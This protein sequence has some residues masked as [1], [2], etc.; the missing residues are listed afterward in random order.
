MAL[1]ELTDEYAL[2][3]GCRLPLHYCVDAV[4]SQGRTVQKA[5]DTTCTV[6]PFQSENGMTYLISMKALSLSS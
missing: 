4:L 2:I 3:I 6:L 5:R 1:T